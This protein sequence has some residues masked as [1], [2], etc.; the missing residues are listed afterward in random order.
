MGKIKVS[1]IALTITN[2]LRDRQDR[3]IL[4]CLKEININKIMTTAK[5]NLTQVVI[6]KI[7]L[8]SYNQI[9]IKCI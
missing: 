7:L 1:I 4:M 6:K 5:R 9:L 2:H 8:S 3:L